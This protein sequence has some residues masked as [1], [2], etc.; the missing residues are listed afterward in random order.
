MSK[1]QK[2][3]AFLKTL[4][5]HGKM[6]DRMELQERIG[7][8]ERDE[9]C[10]WRALGL[11]SLLAVF[12][13]CGICYSAVLIPEFFQNSP[14][15]VVKI[16]TGLGLASL[17]CAVVFLFSW[18]WYR[19]VLNRVHE[20]CRRFVMAT[21]EPRSRAALAQSHSPTQEEQ[22]GEGTSAGDKGLETDPTL[23]PAYQTYSQLFGIRRSS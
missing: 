3:T 17:I 18:L 2:Q 20:E 19:G 12:C 10:A 8:A 9:M 5:L 22:K 1:R 23:V 15:L 16:F 21:F 4:I 6:E 11:V 13:C 14:H 7:K